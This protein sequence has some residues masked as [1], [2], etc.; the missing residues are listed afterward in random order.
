M[1]EVGEKVEHILN[2]EWLL[3]VEIIDDGRMICRRKNLSEIIINEFEI[4]KV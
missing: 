1:F 2:G 4:K 3:I